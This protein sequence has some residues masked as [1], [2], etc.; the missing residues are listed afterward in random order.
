MGTVTQYQLA[1]AENN[2]LNLEKL[3][4]REPSNSMKTNTLVVDERRVVVGGLQPDG[5]GVIEIWEREKEMSSLVQQ[6]QK[7]KLA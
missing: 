6:V 2:Q 4:Q 3:W 1:L 5:S 7:P